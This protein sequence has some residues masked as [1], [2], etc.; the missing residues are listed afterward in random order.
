MYIR[1]ITGNYVLVEDPQWRALQ[2][3]EVYLECNTTSAPVNIFLPYIANMGGFLNVKVNVSDVSNNASSHNINIYA[4]LPNTIDGGVSAVISTNNGSTTCLIVS[5]TKWISLQGSGTGTVGALSYKFTELPVSGY[6]RYMPVEDLEGQMFDEGYDYLYPLVKIND[7]T[8]MFISDAITTMPNGTVI[9][10]AWDLQTENRGYFLAMRPSSVNPQILEKVSEVAM[11]NQFLTYWHNYTVKFEGENRVKLLNANF[12]Y[13]DNIPIQSWITEL[14]LTG[15]VLTSVDTMFDFGGNT[16][17]SLFNSLTG[18]GLPSSDYYYGFVTPYYNGD[19]KDSV[20]MSESDMGWVYY[21]INGYGYAYTIGYNILTGQTIWLDCVALLGNVTNFPN[22][23]IQDITFHDWCSHPKGLLFTLNDGY[24]TTG[25]TSLEGVTAIW[26]P[27]WVNNNTLCIRVQDRGVSSPNYGS[28]NGQ[29]GGFYGTFILSPK[30]L[31]ILYQSGSFDYSVVEYRFTLD[32]IVP[33]EFK[34]MP[35]HNS[36]NNLSLQQ[37]LYSTNK[38]LMFLIQNPFDTSAN[39]F[40]SWQ[41][42]YWADNE[43]D[44][45]MFSLNAIPTDTIGDKV[46]G[47]TLL[48]SSGGV[49]TTMLTVDNFKGKNLGF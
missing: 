12:P 26:S 33:Y 28:Q 3:Q 39:A 21:I 7:G 44:P 24:A 29:L 30:N 14:T 4:T 48:Y 6:S 34:Q 5:K 17:L 11:S 32:S 13:D 15:D 16:I 36:V 41:S 35:I 42:C 47:I 9:Y 40:S 2:L 18:L 37:Y 10:N 43:I 49:S 20:M 8:L 1:Q 45:V 27:R 31:F 22:E 46:Y 38:G 23:G 25:G 19:D